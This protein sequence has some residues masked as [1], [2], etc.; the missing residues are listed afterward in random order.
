[1]LSWIRLT[2]YW[3]MILIWKAFAWYRFNISLLN[4]KSNNSNNSKATSSR[5][6]S[7]FNFFRY[8]IRVEYFMCFYSVVNSFIFSIFLRKHP[9][10]RFLIKKIWKLLFS[11]FCKF[12]FSP[13]VLLRKVKKKSFELFWI[14][15]FRQ[16]NV[17]KTAKQ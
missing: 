9:Y 10:T 5:Q 11:L 15:H 7:I 3:Y 13:F 1:M 14:K 6:L 12:T 2:S 17:Q 16:Q 8:F 4:N